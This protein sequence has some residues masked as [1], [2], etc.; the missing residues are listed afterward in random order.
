LSSAL[1]DLFL[2]VSPGLLGIISTLTGVAL[3]EGIVET[4]QWPR[5]KGR[6]ILNPN[7]TGSREE[8]PAIG[9]EVPTASPDSTSE[10]ETG[11]FI[12]FSRPREELRTCFFKTGGHLLAPRAMDVLVGDA[13]F[14][15]G[16]AAVELGQREKAAPLSRIDS[17][18][19]DPAF[20]LAS[21][22]GRPALWGPI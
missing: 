22:L 20:Y 14:P 8:M 11:G 6:D 18:G 9:Q 10:G 2:T 7:A 5:R 21:G 4:V 17:Q 12:R 15:M 16:K 13:V 1:H 3:Q 19:S